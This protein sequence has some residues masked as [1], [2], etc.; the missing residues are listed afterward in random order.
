M[1][2]DASNWIISSD[3]AVVI[4][5]KFPKAKFHYL[6]LPRENIRDI[7]QVNVH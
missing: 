3:V 6:V 5:D 4:E 1:M 7:F 2:K